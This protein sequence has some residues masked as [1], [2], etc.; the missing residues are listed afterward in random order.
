M[1]QEGAVELG[2]DR[3]RGGRGMTTNPFETLLIE[4]RFGLEASH[5]QTLRAANAFWF[6]PI[7]T[8]R[9]EI[10]GVRAL[11]GAQ[12]SECPVVRIL[13]GE[14]HGQA[15]TLVARPSSL[16]PFLAFPGSVVSRN[17]WDQVAQAP[18]AV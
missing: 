1:E 18:D 10:F 11:P 17:A 7:G 16:I 13:D 2:A 5:R 15:A 4:F 8:R 6:L 14:A 12:I 3:Q 9:D